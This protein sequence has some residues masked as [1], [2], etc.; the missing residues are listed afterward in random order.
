MFS[1]RIL[2]VLF[3][4][5]A[6]SVGL[7][8]CGGGDNEST[9][10]TTAPARTTAPAGVATTPASTGA[11]EVLKVTAAD[12]KFEPSDVD[13]PLGKEVTFQ[14]TN[15]GSTTHTLTVYSDE[16][17]TQRV[18]GAEARAAAGQKAE[19]TVTFDKAGNY[20]FRCEIH[21]T[22]MKGEIKVQ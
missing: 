12:F 14:L 13:A 4:A 21:P 16:A 2:I 17:H 7:V 6:V 11:A 5:M 10:A 1:L 9:S 18:T 19:F 8:A 15:T 22:Q 3:A 20:F